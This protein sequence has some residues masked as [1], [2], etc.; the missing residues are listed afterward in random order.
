ML[1]YCDCAEVALHSS[2]EIA[3][4][5]AQSNRNDTIDGTFYRGQPDSIA[6]LIVAIR[7][8]G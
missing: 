7:S 8:I 6:K 3:A 1:R 2:A 5:S 4:E